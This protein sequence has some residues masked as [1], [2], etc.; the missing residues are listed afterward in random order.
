MVL[1][2]LS[3]LE[4]ADQSGIH[5][6][7]SEVTEVNRVSFEEGHF[8]SSYRNNQGLQIEGSCSPDQHDHYRRM[9]GGGGGWLQENSEPKL[10]TTDPSLPQSQTPHPN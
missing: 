6:P 8:S 7:K 3:G 2:S 1:D 4:S 10:L 9:K 5:S